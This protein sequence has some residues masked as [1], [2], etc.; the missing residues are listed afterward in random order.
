M[1]GFAAVMVRLVRIT[2]WPLFALVL[3]YI[4]TGLVMCGELGFDKLISYDYALK[5][6]QMFMWPFIV[7][8]LIHAVPATYLA[9][10]RR[11]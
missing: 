6:H 7:I 10:R 3:L 1:P 5:L 2:S 4:V 9:F 8:S 11:R